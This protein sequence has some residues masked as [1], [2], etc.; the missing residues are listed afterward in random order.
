MPSHV[1]FVCS[2]N[3]C[4]SPLAEA[5]ARHVFEE[6]G[7]KG[8]SFSSAGTFGEDGSCASPSSLEVAR[9][10]ELDLEAF[11]SRRLTPQLLARVDIVLVMEPVHRSSVLGIAP[12]ADMKTFLL[13]E[14]AGESGPDATVPDPYGGSMDSYRRTYRKLVSLLRDA[15]PKLLELAAR[16]ADH[17]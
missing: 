16:E 15:M 2:G 11:S 13:G 4:R 12:T 14:L 8:F 1:L 10:N 3:T 6:E 9:E 5:I 17:S 7:V